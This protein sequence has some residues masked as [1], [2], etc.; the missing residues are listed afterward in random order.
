MRSVLAVSVPRPNFELSHMRHVEKP[1]R[2]ADVKVLFQD[3]IQ[4]LDGHLVSRKRNH[5]S[6]EIEVQL[7]QGR[8]LESYGRNNF[9]HVRTQAARADPLAYDAEDT[10][11]VRIKRFSSI[12]TEYM[13][14]T[15]DPTQWSIY[16]VPPL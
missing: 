10:S 11:A 4:V 16:V 5:P 13:R 6:A 15:F 1:G 2:C 14:G 8:A 12:A 3:S 7:V 9:A